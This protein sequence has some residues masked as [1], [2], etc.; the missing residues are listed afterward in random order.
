VLEVEIGDELDGLSDLDR[1]FTSRWATYSK[2]PG[3]GLGWVPVEHEPWPLHAA[4]IRELGETLTVATGLPAPNSPAVA[5]Y[6]PGVTARI[7]FPH[8]A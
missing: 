2:L 6:S 3:G 8:P 5:H 4:R 1:F 7:G